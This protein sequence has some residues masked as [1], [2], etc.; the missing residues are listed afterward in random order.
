MA[1]LGIRNKL[2]FAFLA[3]AIFPIILVF[4]LNL[5][6]NQLQARSIFDLYLKQS[7]VVTDTT[8]EKL[9]FIIQNIQRKVKLLQTDTE[10]SNYAKAIE[11]SKKDRSNQAYQ[12]S[13]NQ[14]NRVLQPLQR[15]E[16]LNDIF[17][18]DQQGSIIYASNNSHYWK[19]LD[20]KFADIFGISLD[21]IKES[22]LSNIITDPEKGNSYNIMM[23]APV[24]DDRNQFNGYVVAEVPMDVIYKTLNVSQGPGK[25]TQLFLGKMVD[26]KLIAASPVDLDYQAINKVQLIKDLDKTMIEDLETHAKGY[27][28]ATDFQDKNVLFL[29]KKIPLLNLL[30]LKTD[31]KE[32]YSNIQKS[33]NFTL[34][35]SILITGLFTLLAISLANR[36]TRPLVQLSKSIQKAGSAEIPLALNIEKDLLQSNDEIGTLAKA[37]KHRSALLEKAFSDLKETQQQ[38]IL[39][40]KMAALGNLVAGVAHEVNTP[41]GAIKASVSN[42]NTSLDNALKEFPNL[43]PLLGNNPP[44]AIQNM[45][46]ARRAVIDRLTA[47]NIPD[48]ENVSDLLMDMD[49]SGNIDQI[50]PIL[51]KDEGSKLLELASYFSSLKKNAWTIDE[52]TRRIS[53]I[54]FALRN[55]AHFDTEN[56]EKVEEN[57]IPSIEDS[58]TLYQNKLKTGVEVIRNYQDIPKIP[59]QIDQL[60]QVWVNLIQ[61]AIDAMKNKGTLTIDVF[62]QNDHVCARFNDTGMGIPESAKGRIFEPFFTTKAKGEGSGIGLALVK[63]VVENHGGKI[64]VSSVPGN[65]TFTVCLPIHPAPMS[66]NKG[67][68]RDSYF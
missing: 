16:E 52:S 14:L 13:K 43:K 64:D 30:I 8:A 21:K 7:Q 37:F 65:T 50:L 35:S 66:D 3:A 49:L 56:V 46:T 55:Y 9:D 57:I 40:E 63:R 23:I 59:C 68:K 12:E 10:F 5:F 54:V 34:L 17:V 15:L 31:I 22:Y 61:N 6:S 51:R 41:L 58:L 2:L 20:K 47:E 53:R 4:C 39:I 44:Q 25:T 29:W 19:Y 11:A 33:Q 28:I 24:K 27:G 62:T 45:R 32:I 38:L 1:K 48:A 67:E 36:I 18:I 60:N 42:I 26:N